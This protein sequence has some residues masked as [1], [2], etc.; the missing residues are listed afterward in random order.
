ML[1]ISERSI[2]VS[3]LASVA[4]P[5]QINNRFLLFPCRY[6][7]PGVITTHPTGTE[8]YSIKGKFKVPANFHIGNI[9][10]A[11]KWNTTGER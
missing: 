6:D 2:A 8:D 5:F 4:I 3:I 11:P 9:G 1:E 10:L 7:Y